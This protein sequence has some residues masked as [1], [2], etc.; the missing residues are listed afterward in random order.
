MHTPGADQEV[1]TGTPEQDQEVLP[2]DAADHDMVPP[3]DGFQT[4]PA[5][6]GSEPKQA[7][8]ALQDAALQPEDM[9]LTPTLEEEDNPP[10]AAQVKAPHSA[11]MEVSAYDVPQQQVQPYCYPNRHCPM[12]IAAVYLE[13]A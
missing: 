9:P 11:C 1:H 2:L 5:E 6:A 12:C 7:E 3:L 8:E 10:A 4:P 13:R